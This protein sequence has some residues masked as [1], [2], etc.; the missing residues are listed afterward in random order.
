MSSSLQR[1]LYYTYKKKRNIKQE[2]ASTI[3]TE[4]ISFPVSTYQ[5][6]K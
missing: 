2:I 1:S 3:T 4:G 6:A 5:Y